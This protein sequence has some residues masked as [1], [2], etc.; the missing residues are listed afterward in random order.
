MNKEELIKEIENLPEFELKQIAVKDGEKYH[1][2]KSL[3]AIVEKGKPEY[4][5]SVVSN[6]YALVQFKEVF[7]PAVEKIGEIHSCLVLHHR[8]KAYLEIYPEGKDFEIDEKERVGLSLRNSVN[9]VWAI[10]V[11][12]VISSKDFPTIILPIKAVK[13]VRKIHIGSTSITEDFLKVVGDVKE[14]WRKIV[15]EFQ[16]Y[17]LEKKDLEDF[18]KKTKIGKRVEKKLE[19]IFEK[20]T[21]VS[22]WEVFIKTIEEIS[23]RKFKSEIAKKEK[24]ERISQAIF[25]YAVVLSI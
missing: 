17:Q 14:A 2:N 3:K 12:F 25:D 21:S 24:L 10:R 5:I 6:K 4:I 15:D 20:K 11:N 9:K 7:L 16:A 1:D 13:G 19:E 22:L 23:K 8:G 18:A